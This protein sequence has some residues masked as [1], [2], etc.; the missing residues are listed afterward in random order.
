MTALHALASSA[1]TAAL[2][3]A[4][5]PAWGAAPQAAASAGRPDPLAVLGVAVTAGA[6]PGYVADEVCATCHS[7]LARSFAEVGMAKS[8]YRPGP[9]REIEDFADARF[10]H[11]PS[12]E[13]YEMVRQEGGRLLFRRHQ[14]DP[15]GRPVNPFEVEVDWILGS[16]HHARTYL[17]RTPGGELYQLPIAWYGQTGK[18]G[19]APGYDRPDHEGVTRRVRREC[20]FC[21]NAYPDVEAG[22]DA[23]HRPPHYPAALPEGVGCQ[24]CHGPGAEHAR[25]AVRGGRET[26]ERVREAIVNPARLAPARRDEICLGCHLQ[27]AVAQPGVRRVGRPDYSFRPGEPLADYLV[28]V[29]V[30]EAGREPEERFEINHHPYRLMQSRCF[31]ESAGRLSCLTCHDPH[32]KVPAAGRAAHYRAACRQCHGAE[33]CP[34]TRH[35][36]GAPAAAAADCVSC[37]MPERRTQDV[38]QV[39]MTDHLIQRRA[40]PAVERLRPLAESDPE[41]LEVRLL[42]QPGGPAGEEAEIYRALAV[43]RA[44]GRAVPSAI[45]RLQ[46]LLGRPGAA[47]SPSRTELE[48]DLASAHLVAR[49]FADAERTLVA[50]LGRGDL[51]ADE[52]LAREWLAVAR[53]SLGRHDEAIE[54]LRAARDQSPDR[55]ETRFNLGRLL[56]L[57][58]KP[59]EAAAELER[60]V[61]LRPNFA[62]AWFRLGDARAA[63]GQSAAAED[64]YRRALAVDPHHTDA[65]LAL[66]D[67]L[68]AG[69][70]R[71]EATRLLRHALGAAR[72]PDRVRQALE[73]R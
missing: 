25:R 63:A 72:H 41:L 73:A 54:L 64:A 22:S 36:G 58:G 4:A 50:L 42:E 53:S 48:L 66:A 13:R 19:M 39:T 26:P 21:H 51:G 12:G 44:H 29:D 17:Y 52:P 11:S 67:L 15:D 38:V 40:A 3:L 16:G 8:F 71:E 1:A 32:R 18:W 55:P 37:H 59:G 33:A 20:M 70:K 34:E 2:A 30:R 31:R 62:A 9:G 69:G 5:A 27:P 60:A 43:V 68:R 61:A 65:Y 45:D 7:E 24:R 28:Q 56:L 49:R 46:V 6:A 35:G 47:A 23:R 14:L 10:V 57:T